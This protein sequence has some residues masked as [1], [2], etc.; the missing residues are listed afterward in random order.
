[1]NDVNGVWMPPEEDG[2]ETMF[3]TF[4]RSVGVVAARDSA[5]DGEGEG[6]KGLN[7]AWLRSLPRVL[8]IV[9]VVRSPL[10]H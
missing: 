5:G 3:E 4:P 8:R 1:M 6:R 9:P 10:R 7:N 2:V